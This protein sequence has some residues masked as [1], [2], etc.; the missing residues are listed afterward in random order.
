[1]KFEESGA[2]VL[3][4]PGKYLIYFLLDGDEV[5]YI[6]KTSRSIFWIPNCTLHF[7]SVAV[8]P[9]EPKTI[10]SMLG[11]YVL[12]YMPKHNNILK[13][14]V[15][16]DT[17]KAKIRKLSGNKNYSKRDLIKDIKELGINIELFNN[18]T[19]FIAPED[20][21]KICFLYSGDGGNA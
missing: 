1:M 7:S 14:H 16:L 5:V 18:G 6:G 19:M 10:D 4:N 20:F 13:G 2:I 8:I 3:P 17:A 11:K 15:S 12:K 21:D 9:A